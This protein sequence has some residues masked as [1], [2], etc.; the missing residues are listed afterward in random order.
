MN[1]PEPRQINYLNFDPKYL[2]WASSQDTFKFSSITVNL[3]NRVVI[4]K[5]IV[6]DALT[7]LGDVGG[8]QEILDRELAPILLFFS[9]HLMSASFVTQ[10]FRFESSSKSTINKA[11]NATERFENIQKVRLPSWFV[12]L[13]ACTFGRCCCSNRRM[14]ALK[15]GRHRLDQD[16]DVVKF[17]HSWRVL[18]SMSRLI[19]SQQEQRL[20][21][22][23]H[24][25]SVLNLSSKALDSTEDELSDSKI[26]KK[27]KKKGGLSQAKRALQSLPDLTFT[28][29]L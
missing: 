21:R 11:Q 14:R 28:Q 22:V 4:Q 29:R 6:Y 3:S 19:L 5:R 12:L 26:R 15:R 10:L 8:L 1:K 20:A 16:L 2:E 18:A 7:M 24:R 23:Q 17:I 9:E 27:F 25:D 13:Q